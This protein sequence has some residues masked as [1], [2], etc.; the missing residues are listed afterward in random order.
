MMN[1]VPLPADELAMIHR[2]AGG[3]AH[4]LN[5]LLLIIMG[6]AELLHADAGLPDSG[7]VFLN[8][9]LS[10]AERGSAFARHL[11]RISRQ[12]PISP[13]PVNLNQLL[14]RAEP[15][16]RSTLGSGIELRCTGATDLPLASLDVQATEEMLTTLAANARAAMPNGGRYELSTACVRLD[17]VHGPGFP[18]RRSGEFVVL[19]AS[20]TGKAVPPAERAHL[21]EPYYASSGPGR[22]PGL[23][24][25]LVQAIVQQH[26]GWIEVGDPWE[27]W[28]PFWMYLPVWR[29]PVS[30]S[31]P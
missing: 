25:A 26:G 22:P 3:V 8:Q 13:Q 5:N 31:I 24:W 2:F 28:T 6:N 12:Q 19:R 15:G 16:I 18:G 29:E 7:R 17:G 1:E 20:D 21:F 27:G 23:G 9:I 4:D 11:A 14:Q 30:N 10:A